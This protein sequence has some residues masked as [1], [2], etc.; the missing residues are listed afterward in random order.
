MSIPSAI[1]QAPSRL[2]LD[3]A[4]NIPGIYK[5]RSQRLAPGT[6]DW[7]LKK[8]MFWM[9]RTDRPARADRDDALYEGAGDLRERHGAR[10]RV[11]EWSLYTQASIHPR[12]TGAVMLGLLFAAGYWMTSRPRG[13]F[14]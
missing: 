12:V 9:Q 8:T 13:A 7:L 6:T 1:R 2:P 10:S 14:N 4:P 5:Q 3:L 11:R